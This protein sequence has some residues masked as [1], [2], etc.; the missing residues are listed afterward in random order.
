M[1]VPTVSL[2]EDVREWVEGQAQAHSIRVDEF[3][4]QLAREARNR[5]HLGRADDQAELERLLLE[6]LNSGQ[7]ERVTAQWWQE[8]RAE[9]SS[10]LGATGRAEIGLRRS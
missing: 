8:F 7:G 9:L 10:S 1:S 6:G 4:N 2:S 5:A 3:V